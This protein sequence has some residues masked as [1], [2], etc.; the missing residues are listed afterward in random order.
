MKGHPSI[1]TIYD[2]GEPD[3]RH[4]GDRFRDLQYQALREHGLF[5]IPLDDLDEIEM[6]AIKPHIKRIRRQA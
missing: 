1:S 3:R 4:S 2:K 5:V 6:L